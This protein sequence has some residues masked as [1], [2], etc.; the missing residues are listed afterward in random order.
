MLRALIFDF[1]GLILDTETPLFTA[2]ARTFQHHGETP[3]GLD[4][5]AH[6]LGRHD[7]DPQML[8]PM[9]RLQDALSQALDPAEVQLMRRRLRDDLLD[10]QP[11]QPGVV[12]LLAEAEA[13]GLDVAIASS[14]PFDWIEG[15]LVGHD[16]LHRFPVVSSAGNGVPGKPHP[17]V[18]LG[19]ARELEVDPECCLALEDSPNGVT[20]AKAAGARCVAVPTPISERL[21]LNHADQV[22]DTLVALELDA[23]M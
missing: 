2:W 15:H 10:A 9:Q 3:I 23:W 13:R 20:A 21:D 17:A 8:D 5:W 6:S 12:E 19:A 16:L 4:E 1:D 22:L 14:S 11:I 18:Y 7:D